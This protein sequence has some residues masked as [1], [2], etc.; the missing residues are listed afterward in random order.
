LLHRV[1]L[2][3]FFA[4]YALAFGLEL[5]HLRVGRP[6]LR[7]L[8]VAAG[9][10]GLFAHTLYL[11]AKQPPLIW[12][13]SWMLFVAWVLAIFYLTGAIHYRR[14][15]WG[16]FVLPLVLGLLALGVLLGQPP[17]D[18]KGLWQEEMPHRLWGPVHAVLILLATVGVCVAFLAS[19]MYLLQ[20]RRL[21]TKA[22]P[23]EGMRLLSLERLEAMNRRAIVL[24][25]PLLTAGVIAGGVIIARGSELVAW[26]DLRV[27]STLI[28]WCVFA[29]LMY[30]RFGHHLRGRQVAFL[31]IAAFLMLLCCLALAHP[32][33]SGGMGP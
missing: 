32:L 14:L 15:T 27:I 13:F 30:L 10:A 11:I 21:R 3:C 24:A 33:P 23:G 5:L 2:M 25:F 22:L 12:Q 9:S 6:L 1:T 18:Q 19:L 29:L 17:A 26:T 7:W 8:A 31:T 16:V 28:L 4:S 20:S